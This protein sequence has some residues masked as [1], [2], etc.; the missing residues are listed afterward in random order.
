MIALGVPD[1][2]S[3]LSAGIFTVLHSHVQIDCG[4]DSPLTAF[5]RGPMEANPEAFILSHF[6]YDHYNGLSYALRTRNRDWDRLRAVCFPRVPRFGQRREY[7]HCLFAMNCYLLG[8]RTGSREVE[9]L[10]LLFQITGRKP[11][12]RA[13]SAGESAMVEGVRIEALWPPKEYEDA[14][15]VA[16]VERAIA[17]FDEA[18]RIDPELAEIYDRLDIDR[19]ALPMFE[20]AD[21]FKAYEPAG[22]IKEWP[23]EDRRDLRPEVKKANDS[24]Q[25]AANHISLAFHEDNRLLFMGD[26]DAKEI[27]QVVRELKSRERL[28]FLILISPH[29]G[30]HWHKDLEEITC[31]NAVSSTGSDLIK[32]LSPGY[33]SISKFN[34]CTFTNGDVR[35]LPLSYACPGYNWNPCW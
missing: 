20:E 25:K 35:L 7:M 18:R 17:D 28:R 27:Q 30:T 1:V 10:E 33:K 15:F 12:Y 13:L 6:H 3:G 8:D 9:L 26:L 2:G 24:L 11:S 29:H 32:K 19:H 22:A 5:S 21:G 23:V 16:A 31:V 34:Y 4:G 14:D